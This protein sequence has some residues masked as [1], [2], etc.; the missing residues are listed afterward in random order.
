MTA[1]DDKKL[2][3]GVAL[4]LAAE[5]LEKGGLPPFGVVLGSK[6]DVQLL[7][8]KSFSKRTVTQEDLE[9]YWF[10]ELRGFTAADGCKAVCFCADVGFPGEK[11]QIT[12]GLLVHVEHIEG[13]AEDMGYPYW[14]NDDSRIVFGEPISVTS[15]RRAF[16]PATN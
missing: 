9:E 12:R 16:S 6:R 8:P 4:R 7:M 1:A 15:E 10:R 5:Q 3:L 14:R 2:L 11:E 13:G